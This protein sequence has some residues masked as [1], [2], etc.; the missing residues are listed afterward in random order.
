[1]DDEREFNSLQEGVGYEKMWIVVIVFKLVVHF[2]ISTSVMAS[3]V[4]QLS[5]G[6]FSSKGAKFK[7]TILSVYFY[8]G[9]SGHCFD[10]CK[11]IC[12]IYF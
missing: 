5:F 12:S 6:D 2:I 10:S 7:K 8:V 3:T 11:S 1:M 9:R 4:F